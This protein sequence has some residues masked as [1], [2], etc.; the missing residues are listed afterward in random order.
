MKLQT[1]RMESMVFSA[2]VTENPQTIPRKPPDREAT[3]NTVSVSF[4]DKLMGV[5]QNVPKIR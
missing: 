4:R 3:T 5:D 2:V 1:L